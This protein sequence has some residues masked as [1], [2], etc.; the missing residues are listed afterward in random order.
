MMMMDHVEGLGL[1]PLGMM[2]QASFICTT[3]ILPIHLPF[4]QKTPFFGPGAEGFAGQGV[5]SASE[6][7][8]G[9]GFECD[10]QVAGQAFEQVSLQVFLQEL[11]RE[12][13]RAEAQGPGKGPG[14]VL[15]QGPGRVMVQVLA[16]ELM[17]VLGRALVWVRCEERER[18]DQ[19]S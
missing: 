7:V 11:R 14:R 17:W 15:V 13:G 3:S 16:K 10:V 1:L 5:K 2:P 8:A 19:S 4:A 6:Q 18:W 9:Q 12:L